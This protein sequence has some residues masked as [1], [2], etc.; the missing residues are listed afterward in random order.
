M[1]PKDKD[2][3]RQRASLYRERAVGARP[4]VQVISQRANMTK[5]DYATLLFLLQCCFMG[6]CLQM[7]NCLE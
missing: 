5:T 2:A 7:Q 1:Q 4:D 3:L 6:C